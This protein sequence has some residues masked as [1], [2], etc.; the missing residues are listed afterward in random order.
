MSRKEMQ[1]KIYNELDKKSIR[2]T[3][4]NDLFEATYFDEK[5]IM[6]SVI[7]RCLGDEGCLIWVD[8]KI[9]FVLN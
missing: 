8:G 7:E 5:Y 4:D 3:V 9:G 6:A 2:F 1:L